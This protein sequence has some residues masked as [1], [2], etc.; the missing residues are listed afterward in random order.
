MGF[1]FENLTMEEFYDLM[2]GEPEEEPDEEQED[3]ED[4][5]NGRTTCSADA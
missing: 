4:D 2:Y 5:E 3:A 1:V